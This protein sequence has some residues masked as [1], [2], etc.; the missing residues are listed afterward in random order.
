M[1]T[2]GTSRQPILAKVSYVDPAAAASWLIGVFGF[3]EGFRLAGPD[4][5]VHLVGLATPGGGELLVSGLPSLEP[6]RDR[7]PQLRDPVDA[8]WPNCAY[9][10]TVL[11]PDVDAHHRRAVEEGA[12]I[13][14]APVDQPW[15]LRDYEAI[16]LDGRQWNFSQELAPVDLE[17][18]GATPS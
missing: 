11:V 1:A 13:L 2:S 10:L 15:G 8:G 4:G 12:T 7:I 16:D 6:L 14:Q 3:V 5:T 18:W 17:E 9:S